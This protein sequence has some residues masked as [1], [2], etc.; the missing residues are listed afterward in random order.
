MDFLRKLFKVLNSAQHPWQVTLSI[1]LGMI[2]GLTPM[3]G[4]Q[5][6]V[7]LFIVFLFNIH[8]GLFFAAAALFA[9]IGYLFDPWM[10]QFGFML[11]T[12]E[13]MKELYT[14]WYNNG[15]WRLSHFNNTLVMGATVISLLLALPLFFGLNFVIS[16]YRDRIALYL[17]SNKWLSR[18]GLFKVKDKKEPVL[19]WWGAA[20]YVLL[21][22]GVAAL[23]LLVIDPLLKWGIEKSASALLQRDVRVG[24]VE[25]HLLKGAVNID[26]IEVAG[27]KTDIDAF[28]VDRVAFDL[29][30]NAL[31]LSKTH[32]EKMAFTGVGFATEA[33]MK[34]RYGEAAEQERAGEAVSVAREE[35]FAMPSLELPTPKELLA[36]SDLRSQKVYE[37]ARSEI[38]ALERK[39]KRVQK[40]QLSGETLKQYKSDL[41]KMQA[42]AKTKDPAKILALAQQVAAY[43][44][45]LEEQKQ[46]LLALKKELAI[47]Q[48]RVK[49]LMAKLKKAPQEDYAKLRSTYSLDSSGGI[50]LFGLLF[51]QKIAGYLHTAQSYY[52]KAEPYLK[53]DEV[54]KEV[55]PR[56]EGRWI[57][58]AQHVPTPDLWIARTMLS[59]EKSAQ[60][61]EG[62]I[63]DISDNQRALGRALT[64][65][66]SSDGPLV[67][68]L[69]LEGEDNRLGEK[70]IDTLTFKANTVPMESFDLERMKISNSKLGLDGRMTLV[71][72]SKIIGASSVTFREAQIALEGFGGRGAQIMND[73][74][75]GIKSFGARVEVEGSLE[76]PAI[77]V[78][79]DLDRQLSQ[80][81]KKVMAKEI[82]AY[83]KE[84]KGLLDEQLKGQL[85]TLNGMSG[86]MN[87]TGKLLDHQN[88]SLDALGQKA[89]GLL[90]SGGT[91]K[92]GGDDVKK[93]FRF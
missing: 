22:G 72:G 71:G 2:A 1:T 3:S 50:N 35:G 10:E 27:D 65:D 19:R 84:L 79:S 38:E 47:D 68:G 7:I 66:I 40:E 36:R 55:P 77:K 20:L 67:R 69:R 14:A 16:L 5:T 78:T 56:G 75:K 39:W 89:D 45:K 54:P 80:G 46:A 88:L 70:V 31:L 21:V 41:E 23:L 13:S 51:S 82:A 49:T 33:T 83:E 42:D 34:K 60:S 43:Q 76:T 93:L 92:P 30:M 91:A 87:G 64:F 11:L 48:K 63:K 17:N 85:G 9:G 57:R 73:I 59:G 52:A 8:I 32:I 86:G 26:R 6:L 4:T 61:F 90:E 74:L 53:S 18:L 25:T 15:L 62:L 81:F 44:K 29:D 24:S 37:E 28:S 12:S 58:F